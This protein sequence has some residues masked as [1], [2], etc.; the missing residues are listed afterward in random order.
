MVFSLQFFRT[1]QQFGGPIQVGEVPPYVTDI[2]HCITFALRHPRVSQSCELPMSSSRSEQFAIEFHLG[3]DFMHWLASFF[4]NLKPVLGEC[5]GF[6]RPPH[7]YAHIPSVFH[8]FSFA[9]SRSH[10][11]PLPTS[12]KTFSLNS[13]APYSPL[14]PCL[15][16]FTTPPPFIHTGKYTPQTN[17]R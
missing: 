1:I 3:R 15:Q 16:I 13:A 7:Q 10:R 4:C 14:Q 5:F 2:L 9:I 11:R 17:P 12:L 6:S 8:A